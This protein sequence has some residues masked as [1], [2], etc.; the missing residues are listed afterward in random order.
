MKKTVLNEEFKRMQKLAGIIN[1]N[2][3][4]EGIDLLH[5]DG[6]D[7]TPQS[8]KNKINM[9]DDSG[10]LSKYGGPN[11]KV[12]SNKFVKVLKQ[13][14]GD[15]G[16]NFP[17]DFWGGVEEEIYDGD[18]AGIFNLNSL[19]M[20]NNFT[21]ADAIKLIKDAIEEYIQNDVLSDFGLPEDTNSIEDFK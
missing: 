11:I 3:L 18:M 16:Y 21:Q 15:A 2:E 12:D 9:N 1:E 14:M 10:M 13:Y 4:N 8:I 17:N 19:K 5:Y 20:F 7:Y 6:K